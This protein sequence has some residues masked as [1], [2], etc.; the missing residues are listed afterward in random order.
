MHGSQQSQAAR[1]IPTTHHLSSVPTLYSATD[2]QVYMENVDERNE[3][4]L[5]DTGRVYQMGWGGPYGKPWNFA[6]VG[7]WLVPRT[8]EKRINNFYFYF[9]FWYIHQHL[10]VCT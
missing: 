8:L 10:H 5:N 7:A 4:V 6:Q 1:L 3:Y 9:C 2:D